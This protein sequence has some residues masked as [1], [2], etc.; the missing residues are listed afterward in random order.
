[1]KIG[2]GTRS[3]QEEKGTTED[4]V[5]GWH[6]PLDGHESEQTQGDGDGQG[7]LACC[8]PCGGRER[9][10]TER[11]NNNLQSLCPCMHTHASYRF[12]FSGKP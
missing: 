10:T 2:K 12:C 8:S 4:E 9:D 5:A 3:R 6:H 11:L 7:S 1:M